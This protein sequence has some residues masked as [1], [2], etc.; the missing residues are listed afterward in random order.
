M[1]KDNIM[2]YATEAFEEYSRRGCPTREKCEG[3]IRL[4]VH[5]KMFGQDPKLIVA[6]S[7]YVVDKMKPLLDN[8]DAVNRCFEELEAKDKKYIADA[9]RA[10]YFVSPCGHLNGKIIRSRVLA[11]SME[12]YADE[13]TVYRWLEKAR[14]LFAIKR[15][16][17]I[18][19]VQ[20]DI[21]DYWLNS[22]IVG[23]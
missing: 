2:D 6:S 9:V 10:V 11:H 17:Y 18:A 5:R 14:D 1:K 4:E 19:K 21:I 20:D 13:R 23:S 7:N 15:G 8:I 12:V 16:L 22:S 3:E